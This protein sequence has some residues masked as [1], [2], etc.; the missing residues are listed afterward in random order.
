[1]E[2]KLFKFMKQIY[3]ITI[4]NTIPMFLTFYGQLS[5][6]RFYYINRG[7]HKLQINFDN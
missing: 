2:Q 4:T 7:L 3:F 1:M 5:I 6:D